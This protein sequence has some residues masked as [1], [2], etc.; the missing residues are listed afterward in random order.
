M[1]KSVDHK[2]CIT[3]HF[4]RVG[5]PPSVM[6]LKKINIHLLFLSR[7]K[8]TTTESILYERKK[9]DRRRLENAH[10][11]YAVLKVVKAYP[12]QLQIQ[13]I[14]LKDLNDT[15]IRITPIFHEAF[16]SQFTGKD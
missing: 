3:E 10:L 8:K 14:S 15:L 11:Q 5:G 16:I 7:Q 4:A 9:L 6:Q 2:K 13:D 1:G 12:E